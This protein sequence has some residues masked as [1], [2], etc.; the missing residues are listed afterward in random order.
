MGKVFQL[1][2]AEDLRS[3]KREDFAD[4]VISGEEFDHMLRLCGGLWLHRGEQTAPH[5]ELTSGKCS[6][7]YVNT[8]LLL[9]YTN[10]SMLL[11]ED[12]A[13]I[14]FEAGHAAPDW[15]VGSDHAAAT[16]SAFVAYF[17]NH[18]KHEFTEKGPDGKTQ[19]W[20][21]KTI[22]PDE[23]VSQVE[24]LA[25]TTATFERVRKGLVDG[26]AYPVNFSPVSLVLV[27]RTPT[28]EF[29]GRPL[30]YFRHYDIEAWEPEECPLCAAGSQRLRPKQHWAELVAV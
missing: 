2:R 23:V 18:A 13:K 6:N 25:A 4:E 11:A 24:E 1:T 10:I 16:F 8:P 21:R 28:F 14:F 5:A 3:V 22:M 26:N 30:L 15:V 19:A 9:E 27:H 29:D 20:K 17:M 12:L 7:G